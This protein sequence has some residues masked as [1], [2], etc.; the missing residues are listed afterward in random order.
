MRDQKRS[1]DWNLLLDSVACDATPSSARDARTG[2]RLR[3]SMLSYSTI[4]NEIM[5]GLFNF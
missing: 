3:Y 2:K 4:Q 1:D 5:S